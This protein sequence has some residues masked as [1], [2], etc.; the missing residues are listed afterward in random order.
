MF[1]EGFHLSRGKFGLKNTS[2]VR[3]FKLTIHLHQF[4][5]IF[6][7]ALRWDQK[8]CRT[9]RANWCGTGLVVTWLVYPPN[10]MDWS[11]IQTGGY[12]D[13]VACFICVHRC[14][15]SDGIQHIHTVTETMSQGLKT[16]RSEK[17]KCKCIIIHIYTLIVKGGITV[18]Q[19][20][21]H[22][23]VRECK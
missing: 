18:T 10:V 22:W 21:V 20:C 16:R 23:H 5:T 12:V 1:L 15:E 19:T 9:F 14:I 13:R 4:F 8:A 6:L 7:L 17:V 2:C 3:T 11:L